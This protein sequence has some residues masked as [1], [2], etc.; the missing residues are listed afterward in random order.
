MSLLTSDGILTDR[1]ETSNDCIMHDPNGER[2]VINEQ[3]EGTSPADYS[4]LWSTDGEESSHAK[5][6][7]VKQ[8][9]DRKRKRDNPSKLEKDLVH[10]QNVLKSL[11][12]HLEWQ[13]CPK[14]P[15]YRARAN[16]KADGKFRKDIKRLRSKAE[17]EYVQALIRFHN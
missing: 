9:N 14:S 1:A 8:E 10:Y 16:I 11:K 2:N 13:T 7:K 4:D 5:E 17:Q 12:K 3:A 6:H 15:Q